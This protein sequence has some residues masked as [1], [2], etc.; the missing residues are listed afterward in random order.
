MNLQEGVR[1]LSMVAGAAGATVS[2]VWTAGILSNA[3]HAQGLFILYGLFI[4]LL[5]PALGFALPWMLV[6]AIGLAVEGFLQ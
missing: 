6:R 3:G 4:A 1:R 2:L 5:P